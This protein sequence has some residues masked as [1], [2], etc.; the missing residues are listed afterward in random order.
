[1][2]PFWR[3]PGKRSRPGSPRRSHHGVQRGARTPTK[4]LTFARATRRASRRP[5]PESLTFVLVAPLP[6]PHKKSHHPHAH[7]GPAR[8]SCRYLKVVNALSPIARSWPL[9]R[10]CAGESWGVCTRLTHKNSHHSRRRDSR[11]PTKDLTMGLRATRFASHRKVHLVPRGARLP[12]RLTIPVASM[13]LHGPEPAQ[14]LSPYPRLASGRLWER[15]P[16]KSHHGPGDSELPHPQKHS[17]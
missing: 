7:D 16:R 10:A 6:R 15:S 11:T 14:K 12:C 3:S 8:A 5:P 17:P 9:W 1:M 13:A 4:S 2:P